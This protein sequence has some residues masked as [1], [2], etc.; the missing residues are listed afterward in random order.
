MNPSRF[1][2]R[3]GLILRIPKKLFEELRSENNP[4]KLEVLPSKVRETEGNK[5]PLITKK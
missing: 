1:L 2:I 3:L 4:A 5:K